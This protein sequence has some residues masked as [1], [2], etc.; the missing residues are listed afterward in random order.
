M[1]FARAFFL[2]ASWA[3]SA[4]CS[5]GSA[6]DADTDTGSGTESEIDTAYDG[7]PL[8]PCEGEASEGMVCVPGGTYLMGCMPYDIICEED[9]LPLV[10]VTLSPFWVDKYETTYAELLPFLNTLKEGYFRTPY[11]VWFGEEPPYEV[12][13]EN[14]AAIGLNDEDDYYYSY[15]G[16]DCGID[17]AAGGLSQ[18]GARMYCE[19]RGKQLPTEAQWEAAARGQTA[20]IYP[21]SW[22]HL[23]CWFGYHGCGLY[24]YLGAECYYEEGCCLPRP[25][26][27]Y[28]EDGR[29]PS[30]WG[31][32]QMTGNAAEWVLDRKNEIND[33][34]EWCA[35][36]CS[37]PEP[38]EG[39]F[40]IVKG[41]GTL[42][43]LPGTR[44]SAREMIWV[45]GGN[46]R[47][48][49]VRCIVPVS[50]RSRHR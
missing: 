43:S 8:T 25:D 7:G 19:W 38:Q 1:T 13:W 31:I 20:L 26:P 32:R 28:M 14:Y 33:G 27:S 34:H 46:D 11:V 5:G 21:C 16:C 40:P 22:K 6:D 42:S 2:V 3:L 49:G 39:A 9:E 17:A 41:G 45:G 37:D 44:I 23:A 50:D 15:E 29:C 30:P 24:E 12:I 35:E 4:G 10:E 48:T 36:G 47:D 18:L